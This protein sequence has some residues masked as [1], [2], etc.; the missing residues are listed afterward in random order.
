VRYHRLNRSPHPIDL[1]QDTVERI[2]S[3]A[4]A[5]GKDVATFVREAVEAKLVVADLSF[6]SILNPIHQDVDGSG[7]SEAAL[8]ALIDREIAATR[9]ERRAFLPP[10]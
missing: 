5:S 9:A 7:I 3:E 2:Q 10:Q 4:Q 6:R 8:G 1:P